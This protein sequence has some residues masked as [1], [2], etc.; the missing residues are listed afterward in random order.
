MIP[1][2]LS[3]YPLV[4]TGTVTVLNA[5]INTGAT[6]TV[7][8][9]VLAINGVITNSGNIIATNGGITFSGNSAQT[10]P[11]ALFQTNKVK[12]LV[13]NNAAGVTLGGSLGVS[14]V[15][16]LTS[17]QFT[18]GGYLTLLSSATG[19]ARVAPI[20]GGGCFRRCYC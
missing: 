11:A 1:G 2:G 13:I 12:D 18:T 7:S 6:I 10:I 19:T 15:L 14:G 3:N 8:G 5:T 16:T 4:S 9:G 20:T 17:G